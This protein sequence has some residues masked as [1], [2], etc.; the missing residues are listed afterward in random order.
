M[1]NWAPLL[2]RAKVA[3]NPPLEIGH[4]FCPQGQMA[5]FHINR[6]RAKFHLP[7]IDGFHRSSNWKAKHNAP[8]VYGFSPSFLPKPPDWPERARVLGYWWLKEP[9][10]TPFPELEAFLASGPAPVYIGFGSVTVPGNAD[11]LPKL[12]RAVA[13]AKCRCLVLAPKDPG[14]E[15]H[16]P[17]VFISSASVPHSWLFPRMAL[18]IHHGGAGTVAYALKSGVPSIVMPFFGDHHLWGSRMVDTGLGP[19]PV[20]PGKVE[21]KALAKMIVEVIADTRLKENL[22]RMK[23]LIEAE[24]SVG[25]VVFGFFVVVFFS[26]S[27]LFL[28]LNSY[29]R[30]FR[31]STFRHQASWKE[32]ASRL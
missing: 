29:V 8:I 10:Y 2:L 32:L 15:F 20:L 3:G 28:Q 14:P 12:L 4:L 5:R 31:S 13:L 11:L 24:D 9:A 21:E 1:H 18:I 7:A 25:K 22:Q 17:D 23:A 30:L 26:Y 6:L 19:K 27:S 16:S